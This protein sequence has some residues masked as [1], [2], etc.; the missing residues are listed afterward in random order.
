M[1][2]LPTRLVD[3]RSAMVRCDAVISTLSALSEAE[4]RRAFG[5]LVVSYQATP[6]PF[7]MSRQLLAS[8][9]VDCLATNEFVHKAPLLSEH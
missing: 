8:F 2:S 4:Q 6:S 9:V 1:R 3:V 7:R 5:K